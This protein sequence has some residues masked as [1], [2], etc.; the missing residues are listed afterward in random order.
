MAMMACIDRYLLQQEDAGCVKNCSLAIGD[1]S[2]SD[3]SDSSDGVEDDCVVDVVVQQV[4]FV[5]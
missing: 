5:Q 4:G 2:D 1:S 3:S